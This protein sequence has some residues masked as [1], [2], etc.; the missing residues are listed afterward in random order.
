MLR[1]FTVG[2]GEFLTARLS[3]MPEKPAVSFALPGA[4]TGK[5]ALSLYLCAMTEDTQL[6]SNEKQY[7]LAGGVW[8]STQP[9]FRLKC[10]YIVSVWPGA[11][12]PSEAALVQQNILSAAYC[13]IATTATLPMAYLPSAMRGADLPKPV[14]AIADNEL[15]G[16]PEFWASAGCAYRPSFSF[17]ATV[18]LPFAAESYDHVVEGVQVDYKVNQ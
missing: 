13:L 1:R 10:T 12:D 16:R 11:S 14:I 8:V 6:R 5:N 9:P 3:D 4:V 17:T 18:S 2:I 7:E 15:S